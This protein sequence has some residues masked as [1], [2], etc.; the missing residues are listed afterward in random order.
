MPLM[1]VYNP[2][3]LCRITVSCSSIAMTPKLFAK[4]LQQEGFAPFPVL[5]RGSGQRFSRERSGRTQH[6]ARDSVRG[7]AWRLL[8]AVGDVPACWPV[9]AL[10]SEVSA[11]WMEAES[12]WFSYF[13]GLDLA[14]PLDAQCDSRE[15]ALEKCWAWLS[16][17]GFE[18]L[19]DPSIKGPKE[20]RERYGILVKG[21]RKT[22]RST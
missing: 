22:S 11:T 4:F 14:D 19:E 3:S 21:S 18:W 17:A 10:A 6:V 7:S 16:T 12:P 9:A 15:A 5:P 13:T 1:P 8:L 20:W 2:D